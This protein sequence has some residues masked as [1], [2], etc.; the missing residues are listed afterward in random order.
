MTEPQKPPLPREERNS[1]PEDRRYD[2]SEIR[3]I[4]ERA[5][6]ETSQSAPNVPSGLTLSELKTIGSEIGIS[7]QRIIDAATSLEPAVQK[8]QGL[9]R[10]P[11]GVKRVFGLPRPPSD[12]EW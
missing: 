12:R 7:P 6:Q 11:V 3:R 2:E 8:R 9:A 1:M 4:F 5:T 10:L